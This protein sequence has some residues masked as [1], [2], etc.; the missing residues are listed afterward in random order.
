MG[1]DMGS[2][3]DSF[4]PHEDVDS[5]AKIKHVNVQGTPGSSALSSATKT[6]PMYAVV[7][8]YKKMGAQWKED[9]GYTVAFIH[10]HTMPMIDEMSDRWKEVVASGGVEEREQYEDTLE[11]RYETLENQR[12]TWN[13]GSACFEVLRI[14]FE[15]MRVTHLTPLIHMHF[16]QHFH[17]T[18]KSCVYEACLVMSNISNACPAVNVHH[19]YTH[20]VVGWKKE[21]S[22]KT[23]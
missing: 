22:M 2:I 6:S 8:K 17:Y 7:D 11:I 20:E 13:F 23:Q 12:C 21:N 16:M 4:S 15:Q 1:E 3:I 19:V 14:Y 5:E 18:I 9:N 10:Q